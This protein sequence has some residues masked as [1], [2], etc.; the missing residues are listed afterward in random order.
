MEPS[1]SRSHKALTLSTF[2]FTICFA[3][4]TINGV[5]VTFLVD[6]GI[7]DWSVVEIGWL[8]GIP[9]LT[10][11]VMRLPL[12]IL[13]DKYGGK[14]MFVILL[15]FCAVPLALL[16]QA[17]GFY[18]YAI[19]SFFI[20]MVGT[21]FAI[22]IGYT[23]AWYPRHWQGRALGIFGMGN[24]GAA[25][26]TFFAPA[27]LNFLSER[28]PINGW[29]WL[30][31]IY[32]LILVVIGVLFLIFAEH[33]KV[34]TEPKSINQLLRPIKS[35]RVWRFGLY[36][37]L[38]F[39]CFVA[40][41]QWLIPYYVNVYTTTLVLGGIFT[42]FF[43]LPS[44]VIRAFGGYLSDKFGAR[45]VMY[46]VLSSSLILSA[47]LMIPQMEV[48]TTGPGV[49]AKQP[50]VVEEVTEEKI[51]VN[52]TVYL[53]EPRAEKPRHGSFLPERRS[54]QEVVVEQNQEVQQRELLA[55]GVTYIHFEANMWVYTVLVVLIGIVW[56]IGKAAI[57]KHIPEYF[58]KEVGV[59]GGMVGLIGGL[60]GFFCP[61]LFSYLLSVTGIWTS[62]WMLM[63]IVSAISL[64]WMHRVVVKMSKEEAPNIAD[65]FERKPKR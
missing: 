1:L 30:P 49:S 50:G 37:F 35:M 59:V 21:G 22:G 19:L 44:G 26:T 12:G 45:S 17:T 55:R 33:K 57:F 32:A 27:L 47:L 46:W 9:I 18:S 5:L 29:K 58:P 6:H 56:G 14:P 4:W 40:F 36:Y 25:L 42:S 60:G 20:G 15:F 41:S 31:I 39:G 48:Y 23:S 11:S 16:S 10:G 8:L 13:T 63:L 65:Q 28:D 62:S 52:G 34:E 2:A 7:F 54:W 64:A 38:V 53:I 61:I 3:C 24:A 43:S 51:E